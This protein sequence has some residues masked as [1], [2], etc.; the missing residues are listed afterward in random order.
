M[1]AI[2]VGLAPA[3]GGQ[4]EASTVEVSSTTLLA[5]RPDV[6]LGEVRSAVPIVE[7]VGLSAQGFE[8]PA[9]DDLKLR[10]SG[11]GRV[12]AV[13]GRDLAGDLEFAFLQG[14]LFDR[15]LSLTMGRHL[16]SGGAARL[17]QLDGASAD[18]RIGRGL[19]VSAF[20]GVP[21]V[22]RFAVAKG[23]LAYG[24]RVYYRALI[25]TEVGVS[26]A[27]TLDHG[28]TARQ[29]AG[30]D[31]RV[32][33]MRGLVVSGY[34]LWSLAEQ[35]LAE[36][37]I[38]PTWMATPDV[39]ARVE[40]RRTAPDLFLPRRSIFSVFAEMQRDEVGGDVSW[41]LNRWANLF[42]DYFSLW[43]GDGRGDDASA[44]ATFRSDPAARAQFGVQAR[45]FRVPVNGYVQGRVFGSY[46]A[47]NKVTVSLDLD[48]YQ[49]TQAINGARSTFTGALTGSYNFLPGWL[50]VVSAS[51][52]TTVLLQT[53][54]ELFAKL[55]FNYPT[56][57]SGLTP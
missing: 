24:G 20:G 48:G 37:D 4:A 2:A 52:G 50:A 10:V 39:Q 49:F 32:R 18:V 33:L 34:G 42:A 5:V 16:V 30:L 14:R 19:G 25:D 28:L 27:H 43:T 13:E 6:R 17:T 44:R 36:I 3:A 41:Q 26:Y 15:R 23:D 9:V 57:T 35:R 7:L 12:D 53:R 38:G 56:T 29:D 55:V 1:V 11:W 46:R 31:A 45:V 54:Y 21:V 47:M 51:G 40:Y 22:P 8:V